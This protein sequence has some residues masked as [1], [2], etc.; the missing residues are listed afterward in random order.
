[1][2]REIEEELDSRTID[3]PY[4]NSSPQRDAWGQP[5]A[6]YFHIEVRNGIIFGQPIEGIYI[7]AASAEGA[8]EDQEEKLVEELSQWEALSIESWNEF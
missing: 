1:M 8:V 7:P 3:I 4:I 6:S 2:N 5:P